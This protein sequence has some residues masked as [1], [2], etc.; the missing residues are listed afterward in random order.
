MTLDD[1]RAFERLVNENA[2]AVRNFLYRLTMGD[3][4]LTDDLAQ[5]TFLSAYTS[6]RSFRAL[7]R[8]RTWLISIAYREYIDYTRRCREYRLPDDYRPDA[9]APASDSDS[10][11]VEMRHDIRQAMSSLTETERSIVVLFYI[12]DLP[13]KEIC[14]IT[15]LPSGTVKSHLHRAKNKMARELTDTPNSPE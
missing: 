3:A 4:A 11:L 14:R 5:E 2:P 8:F 13:I 10:R 12:D 7:A 6:L 15:G 1:R 9:D